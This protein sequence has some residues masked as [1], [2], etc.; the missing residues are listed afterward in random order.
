MQQHLNGLVTSL[1]YPIV[2][3]ATGSLDGSNNIYG[4]DAIIEEARQ[5]N[6][7]GCIHIGKVI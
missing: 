6:T 3:S 2:D 1:R 4:P 5:E 7:E